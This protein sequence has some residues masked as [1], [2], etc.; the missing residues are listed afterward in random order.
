[1]RRAAVWAL[2]PPFAAAIFLTAGLG[3]SL[4]SGIA[5]AG[6]FAE[7][8]KEPPT[9][10]EKVAGRW[11]ITLEGLPVDHREIL[12]SL[13]VQGEMLVGTL[14]AGQD[15]ANILSGK[16]VGTDI[17]F[18]FRHADGEVFRMTGGIG[19]R[20]LEGNWEARGEKGRWRAEKQRGARGG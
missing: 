17:S 19:P 5:A 4:V 15:T 6:A 8:R 13:G 1:M 10:A 20:G 9:S 2:R 18:S 12:A 7:E 16:I 14:T 3:A 11:R